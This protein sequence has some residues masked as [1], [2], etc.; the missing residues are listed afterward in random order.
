MES[1]RLGPKKGA[2][3]VNYTSIAAAIK[4]KENVHKQPAAGSGAAEP[5]PKPLLINF[6]SAQQ[7]CMR[8]R[9]G[10]RPVPQPT[11]HRGF[12]APYGAANGHDRGYDS[13]NGGRPRPGLRPGDRGA[14]GEVRTSHPPPAVSQ[15]TART[16]AQRASAALALAIRHA[17]RARA[18]RTAQGASMSK[19]R[20]L[21]LGSVP[22]SAELHELA[23]LVEA[24]GVVESL[25]L[26]RPKSCAFINFAEE[27]VACA[28]RAKFTASD[29]AAPEVHGKRLTVNYAKAR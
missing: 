28:V 8:A 11:G 29:D 14:D 7:N 24:T 1:I 27:D 12:R 4:A 25:R 22:D 13:R 23:A 3:F 17:R 10:G 21:Y 9:G 16:R 6:T 19:S 15:N 2:A 18:A 26:V 20:A 5:P